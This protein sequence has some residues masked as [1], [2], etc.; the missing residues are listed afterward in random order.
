V[1][2]TM[3]F[4]I[5]S[6]SAFSSSFYLR[7]GPF[8]LAF[9]LNITYLVVQVYFSAGSDQLESSIRVCVFVRNYRTGK[10]ISNL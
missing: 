7:T 10:Y 9:L 1:H 5:S 4:S 3:D 8:L 6:I 2:L